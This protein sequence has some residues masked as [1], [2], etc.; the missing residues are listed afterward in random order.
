MLNFGDLNLGYKSHVRDEDDLRNLKRSLEN[1]ET[2]LIERYRFDYVI[3]NPPY[4]SYNESSSRGTLFFQFIKEGKVKLNDVYGVNLH[5]VPESPKKYAPKPNLYAFF[6][7]LG[8][9]LLKDGGKLSYIIP[10]TLLTEPDYDVL[11]YHLA[12]FCTI[13][14]IVVFKSKMF[15]ERGLKQNK[16]IPTSSLILFVKKQKA[17]HHHQTK[18]VVYQSPNDNIEVCLEN[19]KKNKL[20]NQ[21]EISQKQLRKNWLNWNF[22]KSDNEF[23]DFENEY[24][25]HSQDFEIYYNH[26]LATQYFNHRF[27]IDG[28]VKL[29]ENL[30]KQEKTKEE[31]YE[32]VDNVNINTYFLSKNDAFYDINNPV[33]FIQGGQG[34]V[35]FKHQYKIIWRKLFAKHFHFADR[36][37]IL[38]GNNYLGIFSNHK[39]EI[40]YLF[41]LL[42]SP[43]TLQVMKG[44]FMLDDEKYGM[45]MTLS[46]I[47][48]FIKVPK[49][50]PEN[51]S[52]KTEIIKKVEQLLAT[53]QIKLSDL[54]DFSNILVQKFDSLLV[55]NEF[56]L[57]K[58]EDKV[59]KCKIKKDKDL[60]E[61]F[62]KDNTENLTLKTL[63]SAFVVDEKAQ[64]AL[65]KEIDD[66]VFCLYFNIQ[67]T[68]LEKNKYY[69]Y[70]QNAKK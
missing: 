1:Q 52:F 30:I 48:N 18:I 36:D 62:V 43:I 34:L 5:S 32:I 59:T 28:G 7:A 60:V 67:L 25:N 51:Q 64:N 22:L 65:K 12:N 6:I 23:I 21:Y 29:D 16:A 41:A 50:T 39:E 46:R 9:G 53:E 27:Y 35:V 57:L 45:F 66:L 55:E 19:I 13:E 68:D 37:L 33:K 24:K 10:Q 54:A 31:E 17:E 47:K 38:S 49:I 61:K 69:Q 14:K 70:L 15:I 8:L 58:S 20:V 40:L 56:L 4:I 44:N 2:P 11:R 26:Q 42:N 63:K 3:G